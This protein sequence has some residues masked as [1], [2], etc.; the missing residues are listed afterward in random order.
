MI[1]EAVLFWQAI[2]LDLRATSYPQNDVALP[3][4]ASSVIQ[5]ISCIMRES[6]VD[7]LPSSVEGAPLRGI[8]DV[9]TGMTAACSR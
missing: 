5:P 7:L 8:Q 6:A 4:T 1:I 3:V 9:H 2:L